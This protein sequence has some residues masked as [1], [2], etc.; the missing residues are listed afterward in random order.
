[1]TPNENNRVI[2]F[3]PLLVEVLGPLSG[4]QRHLCPPPS[5][6]VV[7]YRGQRAG[8]GDGIGGARLAQSAA[9]VARLL[10]LAHSVFCRDGISTRITLRD[11]LA[12]ASRT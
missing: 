1:M 10:E 8:G 11:C 3:L 7:F 5:C 2:A 9:L 12:N 4:T 6:R